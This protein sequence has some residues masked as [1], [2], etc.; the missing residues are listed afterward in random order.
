MD[1]PKIASEYEKVITVQ[2]YGSGKTIEGVKFVDLKLFGDDG[3]NF[4]EIV[5]ITNGKVDGLD[6]FEIK[7]ISWSNILPGTIKA[8]HLHRKQADVWYVPTFS[9]LLVGLADLRKDS[10]TFN[11]KMRIMLGG[12]SNKLL[13]IPEGVA[14]GAGNLW[15]KPTMLVYCTNEQ[16]DPKEPDEGRLPYDLFGKEFW[17][18]TKG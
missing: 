14:H 18:I 12:G 13:Y 3:G 16:F 9:R 1:K 8:F 2:Q 4:S 15:N 5:R 6:G 11:T 7:Q 10:P 17:K